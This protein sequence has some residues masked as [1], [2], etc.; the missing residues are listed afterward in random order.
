AGSYQLTCTPRRRPAMRL[1]SQGRRRLSK[2][3]RRELRVRQARKARETRLHLQRHYANL[4]NEARSFFESFSSVFRHPTF[5][6]FALLM[7]AAVLTVGSHTVANVLRTVGLLAPGD[8]S[9]FHR[10]FSCRRWSML[11][12]G[13]RLA[14]WIFARLVPAGPAYLAADDTV[15]E[16]PGDKVYGKG[17]HRDAV[18][19]SHSYTAFRWGHK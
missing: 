12:L 11:A 8:P 16:H 19:S 2:S 10:F 7:V 9:S 4:P 6:R 3:K 17:C 5:L 15:D 1:S 13:R 18:R 14:G